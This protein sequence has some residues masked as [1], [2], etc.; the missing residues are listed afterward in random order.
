M[1]VERLALALPGW[2]PDRRSLRSLRRQSCPQ[3]GIAYLR[4][5]KKI[6]H[7]PNHCPGRGD[8]AV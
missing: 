3:R 1:I 6:G 5:G 7:S 4:R 2:K 8:R